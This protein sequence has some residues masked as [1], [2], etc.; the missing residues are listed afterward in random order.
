[1]INKDG[2]DLADEV[3]PSANTFNDDISTGGAVGTTIA[4]KVKA[5]NINGES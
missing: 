1:M 5:V 3:N 4:Y 2:T